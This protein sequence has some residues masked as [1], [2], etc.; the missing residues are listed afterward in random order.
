MGKKTVIISSVVIIAAFAI[1][2]C[3]VLFAGNINTRSGKYS[4]IFLTGN[5]TW[6]EVKE[7]LKKDSL[8]YSETSFDMALG[9]I[10]RDKY[11]QCG[12]FDMEP[13]LGNRDFINRVAYGLANKTPL[14]IRLAR[15]TTKVAA[16]LSRQLLADSAS[17]YDYLMQ[18]SVLDSYGL[19]AKNSLA[20]FVRFK[21]RIRWCASPEEVAACI[22]RNYDRFWTSDRLAKAKAC[23]LTPAEVHALASIVEEETNNNEDRRMVAGVYMN[24]LK[25]GM[26][27]QACPTARYASGDFTLDRI[28]AK[29]TRIDSEYNTY[30]NKGL[31]PG[32]IRIPTDASMD[33]VLDF[34]R[35]D[36]L[37]FCANPDFSGTHVYS[38]TFSQHRKVAAQYRRELDKRGIR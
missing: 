9:M 13:G 16:G 35:H 2:F 38:R 24:R 34:V 30:R 31:P 14:E 20:M 23:G 28:L 1:F 5:E 21:D 8:L 33:A 26:P 25:R 7:I 19:E 6:D 18:D 32:P 17:I 27:L 36:Y 37:Y 22:R 12:R 4:S 11:P 3:V 29:H 15:Y 10:G